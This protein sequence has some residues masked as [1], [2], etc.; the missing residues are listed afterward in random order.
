MLNFD[1]LYHP[2]FAFHLSPIT[3][4]MSCE[5]T[6]EKHPPINVSYPLLIAWETHPA[7]IIG[8]ASLSLH[9]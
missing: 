2:H 8:A 3:N 7:F 6:V 1:L 4:M 9:L 5:I